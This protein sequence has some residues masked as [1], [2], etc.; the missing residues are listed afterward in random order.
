MTA[1]KLLKFVLIGAGIVCGSAVAAVFMPRSWIEVGHRMIVGTEF[2]KEPV[3][4]YLARLASGLYALYGGL[5]LVLA[6]DVRKYRPVIAYQALACAFVS[7]A[8][9]VMG[10]MPAFWLIGDALSASAQAIMVLVL[11]AASR[12]KCECCRG[13]GG[14]SVGE[15]D[16]R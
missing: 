2:P 16:K 4:E 3:A 9:L 5:L 7:L 14:E 6:S 12:P 15:G 8:G 10:G 13:G 11:L 1:E